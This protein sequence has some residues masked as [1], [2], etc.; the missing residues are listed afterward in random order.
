MNKAGPLLLVL[1]ALVAVG[2]YNYHRNEGLDRELQ[3]RPHAGISTKDLDVLAAAHKSELERL[4]R[5]LGAQSDGTREVARYAPSD[6]KGKLQ[7]FDRFQT[8]NKAWK[9]L[10]REKLDQELALEGIEKERAL[11]RQGLDRR[12]VQ[13]WR[14]ATTF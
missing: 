4:D 12:W 3:N 9:E 7:G 2:A 11:R 8:R 1:V 13:V 5:K 10:Y 6:L 14:R